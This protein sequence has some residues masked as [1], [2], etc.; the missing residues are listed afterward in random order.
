[1]LALPPTL[2][3]LSTE[4]LLFRRL[5]PADLPH[6]SPFV[7]SEEAMRFLGRGVGG[8]AA[9][10]EWFDRQWARYAA[11]TGGLHALTDR[12]SGELV[13]QCGLLVQLVDGI[14]ELEVGYHLLPAAWGH[15][16]ATE[17]AQACM[18]TAFAF[19]AATSIISIIHADNVRSAAVARR[20]GL[21]L[22]HRTSYRDLP[23]DIYRRQAPR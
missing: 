16:Y 21:Q 8:D 3:G 1:M 23:V 4:R 12:R 13:G 14:R 20:N 2:E 15:G 19:Q 5:V 6:W 7:R 17:A 9:A 22:E 18:R 10:Q 11:G